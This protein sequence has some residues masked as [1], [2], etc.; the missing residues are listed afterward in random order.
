MFLCVVNIYIMQKS[1]TLL[2]ILQ[3]NEA[4]LLVKILIGATFSGIQ[5]GLD[6]V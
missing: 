2:Y 4:A 3:N 6:G 1:L 5:E